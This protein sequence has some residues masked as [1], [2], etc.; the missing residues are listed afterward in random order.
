MQM[1]LY[2]IWSDNNK[3]GIPIIDEQHRGIISTINSLHYFIQIG[4]GEEILKPTLTMLAQYT[5]IHFKTEEALM[6]KANYPAIEEHRVLHKTLIEK[7]KKLSIEISRDKDAGR[8]LKF[9][10]EWWLG[11]INKEDRKYVPFMRKL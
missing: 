9:L 6:A 11:H 2:I 7:T 3:I 8:V 5:K 4:H 10:R 1:T